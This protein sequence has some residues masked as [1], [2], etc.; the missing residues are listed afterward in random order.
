MKFNE[1]QKRTIYIS[2][3]LIIIALVVWI[4]YGMEFFTKTQIIVE[5]TDE[6]FGN[7]YKEFEDK[8]ILGLDYTAAISAVIAVVSGVTIFFQRKSDN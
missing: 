5:K 3:S 8:F 2:L 6:L 1:K 4:A 7:T